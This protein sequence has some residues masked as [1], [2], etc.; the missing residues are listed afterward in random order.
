MGAGEWG[1]GWW[2]CVGVGVGVGVGEGTL[3]A[4]ITVESAVQRFPCESA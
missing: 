4:V 1:R 2:R 3:I